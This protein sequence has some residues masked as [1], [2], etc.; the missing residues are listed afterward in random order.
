MA[1]SETTCKVDCNRCPALAAACAAHADNGA[2]AA[3]LVQQAQAAAAAPPSSS[4]SV[5]P[6]GSAAQDRASEVALAV[7]ALA[8]DAP[9][10]AVPSKAALANA[11]P[12]KA[13]PCRAWA[14]PHQGCHPGNCLR[15]GHTLDIW[16]RSRYMGSCFLCNGLLLSHG[17][18][19]QKCK[20][21][22]CKECREAAVSPVQ[23]PL[24]PLPHQVQPSQLAPATNYE[25]LPLVKRRRRA[26]LL[27]EP[28]SE[29][30]DAE[31]HH[32]T[33]RYQCCLKR[34]S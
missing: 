16:E 2:A 4:S 22:C 23:Q 27:E 30:H 31:A 1:Q 13:G 17:L 19:C 14:R 26:G 9:D 29:V 24:S 21:I 7:A 8:V 34:L 33:L 6:R 28:S 11:V 10:E 5:D 15:T 32:R 25:D 20:N 18:V 12:S 3:A